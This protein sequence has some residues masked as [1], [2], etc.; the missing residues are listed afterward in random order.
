VSEYAKDGQRVL[1]LAKTYGFDGD[2]EAIAL[3]AISDRIRPNAK[4]TIAKFQEQGVAVKVISGDHAATVSTIAKRV[5]INDADKYLSCDGISDEE[6]KA[7]CS[8]YAIFGRVTPEQKVILVKALRAKGHT[9]AMTGDGVNDTLALKE[10]DCSV[11]MADGSEVARKVA[12]IVLMDSDFGSLPDVVREGRRCI[13]NVRMSATLFL[14][15]TIF[16]VALSILTVAAG[17]IYP[18]QPKQ[19]VYLELFIIGIA[20]LLL[21]IEPNN[22]RIE[23]SFIKT[24]LLKSAPNALAMLLPVFTVMVLMLNGVVV[25]SE[26]SALATLAV[27]AAGFVNLLFLCKPYTKWR[28]AVVGLVTL[29]LAG[30][31]PL[32]V[33]LLSDM[34]KILPAFSNLKLLFGTLGL[35][36]GF[37]LLLHLG[38]L[39]FGVT[40]R[41]EKK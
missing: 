17:F 19:L 20:S 4:E 25:Y 29:L 26:A 35:S 33:F 8:D 30:G 1:V 18:F 39:I 12:K 9:V 36:L 11:A 38:R 16:T 23:G 28:L 34:M 2:G 3:I 40:V 15:K 5:G 24:V 27:T 32:T 10:S 7:V 31:I 22:K 37:A 13:N 6:L 21:T 14:M 41:A